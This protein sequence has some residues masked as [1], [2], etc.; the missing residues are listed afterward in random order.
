[1][2][3]RTP[4]KEMSAWKIRVVE[5]FAKEAKCPACAKAKRLNDGTLLPIICTRH[6]EIRQEMALTYKRKRSYGRIGYG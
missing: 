5:H 6:M 2:S 4:A 3:K 1:M